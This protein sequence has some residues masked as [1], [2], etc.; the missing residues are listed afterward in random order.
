MTSAQTPFVVPRLVGTI[1][2]DGHIDET[3]WEAVAPLPLVTHWPTFGQV[4]SER[5]EIRVAYDDTYIYISC[6][7]YAPPASVFAAS[8]ERDYFA[9]ATDYLAIGLD[10]Y[11]DNE[12]SVGFWTTP[13]GSRTDGTTSGDTGDMDIS[14]NTCCTENVG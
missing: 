2:L 11:N 3:A 10:T 9:S 12:S 5:T 4:P 1:T 6:R 8:F 7:C 13:T 14:W